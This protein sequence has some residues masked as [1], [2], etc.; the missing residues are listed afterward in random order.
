MIGMRPMTS[1]NYWKAAPAFA[2][3]FL[4]AFG[5]LSV[6]LFAGSLLIFSVKN[7]CP[8]KITAIPLPEIV[9]RANRGT[10]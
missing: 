5:F 7:Q 2:A 3:L 4:L 10:L 1:R 8:G 9:E 6:A